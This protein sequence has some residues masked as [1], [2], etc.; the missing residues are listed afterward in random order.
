MARC[1]ALQ[2][3]LARITTQGGDVSRANE[4]RAQISTCLAEAEAAGFVIDWTGVA[5]TQCEEIQ[6]QIDQE[7][8]HYKAT[9][10]EDLLKR[11]NGR[12]QILRLGESLALCFSNTV[13]QVTTV[14]ELRKLRGKVN[15][16]LSQA[17]AR[18]NCFND[19]Y[20]AEGN[21]QSG[22]GRYGVNEPTHIERANDEQYRVIV[23]LRAVVSKIQNKITATARRETA[24]SAV[25]GAAGAAA[26]TS[27]V[28]AV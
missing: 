17:I 16:S 6:R 22:C 23:P 14:A 12:G 4:L 3:E 18:R 11:N 2:S 9:A 1:A 19:K 25:I 20:P 13:D 10:T 26:R 8:S 27:G 5:I 21:T 28:P 7:W 24:R 15:Y